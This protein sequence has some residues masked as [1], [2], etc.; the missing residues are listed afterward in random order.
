MKQDKTMIN[1]YIA[2]N[3]FIFKSKVDGVF[4]SN[5]LILGK[6]DAIDNYEEVDESEI[7]ED[8]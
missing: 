3:G 8:E 5:I 6:E 4:L 7:V 2:N 1:K